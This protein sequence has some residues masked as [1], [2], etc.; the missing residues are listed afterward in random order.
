MRQLFEN[1][2]QLVATNAIDIY[3]EYSLQHEFGIFL[4]ENTQADCHQKIQFERNISFFHGDPRLFEKKEIDLVSYSNH[5]NNKQLHYA[6]EF[7]FPKNG[8]Y[9]EQ[10]FSFCKDIAFLEQLK[11]AGFEHVYF[12]AF[13]DDPLFYRG[14]RHDGI[15][16]FFRAN[17]PLQGN[18]PSPTGR[19]RENIDIRGSHLIEWEVVSNQNNPQRCLF[20]EVTLD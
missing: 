4:R 8:Q 17:I 13:V 3:N 11:D 14:S 9:P 20:L 1:F 2:K 10:M 15:Y 18:I 6:I 12:I 19:R 16:Q 5:G 7:K